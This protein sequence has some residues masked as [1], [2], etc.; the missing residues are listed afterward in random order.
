MLWNPCE[1]IL[2]MQRS[3]QWHCWLVPEKS[4]LICWQRRNT[5]RT[6]Q[7]YNMLYE[8]YDQ[9]QYL[10]I[11]TELR[12]KLHWTQQLVSFSFYDSLPTRIISRASHSIWF[13]LTTYHWTQ[14]ILVVVNSHCSSATNSSSTRITPRASRSVWFSL[15]T[16]CSP[17]NN[18]HWSFSVVFNR[19]SVSKRQNIGYWSGQLLNPEVT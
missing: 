5:T 15:T 3:N 8:K 12:L 17:R 4:I 14:M 9:C 1:C 18:A 7:R 19:C 10:S 2:S 13:T 6:I 11:E 16:H